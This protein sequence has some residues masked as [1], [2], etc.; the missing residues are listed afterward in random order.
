MQITKKNLN[1]K[2]NIVTGSFYAFINRF[3]VS[4]ILT[5]SNITKVRGVKTKDILLKI[6]ELPFLQKNFYQG[7]VLNRDLNF[8][9]T[10]GYDFLK[11]NRFNWRK[12]L[13]ELVS[14]IIR[15]FLKPLTNENNEGVFI[16]DDTSYYRNRSKNVELLAKVYDHV[17][18]KYFKGFRILSFC[19]SDGH[20]V[21]PVDFSLL[22]SKNPKN[23]YCEMNT[24]MDKRSTGYKRKFEAINK[25]TDLLVPMIKRA[26]KH[27]IKAKY[28]LMD[29]WFGMPSI[30][31]SIK[32]LIDVICMVKNSSKIHYTL[33]GNKVELKQI[34]KQI[35]K[36]RGR[37]QVKGSQIVE[38]HDEN[39]K[40]MKVKLV[41]IKNRNKKSDYLAI[42]STNIY[43]EDDEIVRIYSKR[44]GIEVFFKM[45][46]SCLKLTGEVELR[47]Y[48]GMVAHISI[49]MFRYVFL[50]VEQRK[51][52]D[53]K[54]CGG[55]FHETIQEM[56][57]ITLM[58]A[59]NMIIMFVCEKIKKIQELSREIIEEIIDIMLGAVT[60]KFGLKLY[61]S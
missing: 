42:L 11:D 50:S 27:G 17:T 18:H 44:W 58:E 20:S 32:P 53:A 9:K 25:S 51:C 16:I 6:S 48:E 21:L 41:F 36:K 2:E 5:K 31:A 52:V 15:S 55:V 19:W 30:I 59:I 29:T 24:N 22:S 40:L 4:S 14:L 33:E 57:D 43:L 49:V 60:E 26:F 61:L 38:I 8:T 12:F 47:S 13:L 1:V 35:K 34:Y 45:I 28:V 37:S 23:R 3:N 7:I 39:G 46:K 54:T 10:T 56:K